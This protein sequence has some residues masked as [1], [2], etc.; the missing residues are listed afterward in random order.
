MLQVSLGRGGHGPAEILFIGAH[1]DDIEIGCGGTALRLAREYPGA[2]VRWVVLASDARRAVEAGCSAERF[3]AGVDHHEV[4]VKTFRD[5]YFPYGG[6]EIKDYFET[7]KAACAPDL[8]FTHYGQDRHQDHRLV[9]ELTW[10]TFR[11]HVILEYEI[12]KYDGGMASPNLF[13]PLDERDTEQK[14]AIL[15]EC[16]GS[17]R[18]K[19]WF[20]RETF[21][22]LMRLRGMECNAP[23]G[24]AE[25]FY[26]R[27]AVV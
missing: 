5:G 27:K 26:C 3:L 1:C 20:A 14:V 2:A 24:Y 10:N 4:T 25:G 13:F 18:G 6:A 11:D 22:G 12:P 9:S 21:L 7:L 17:Q 23:S 19:R 16:F 8:V 15:A